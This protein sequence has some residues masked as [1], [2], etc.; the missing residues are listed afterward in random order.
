MMKVTPTVGRLNSGGPRPY[1]ML[2]SSGEG[3][4]D[5]LT[6]RQARAFAAKLNAAAD[7]ADALFAE[8]DARKGGGA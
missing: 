4:D 8:R 1:V 3:L 2:D 7:K 5:W 6:P